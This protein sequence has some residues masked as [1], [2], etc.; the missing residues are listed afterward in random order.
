MGRISYDVAVGNADSG[1]DNLRRVFLEGAPLGPAAPVTADQYELSRK[2][3]HEACEA[4]GA[5][6]D[7]ASLKTEA[8]RAALANVEAYLV[9]AM[10]ATWVAPGPTEEQLL[11][12]VR[13]ALYVAKTSD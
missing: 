10:E 5:A 8:M 12:E 6:I 7:R 2:R 3:M 13:S 9:L 4:L 1:R 11:T